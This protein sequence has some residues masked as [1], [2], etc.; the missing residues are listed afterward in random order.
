LFLLNG[1]EMQ[2]V[3][4]AIGDIPG[5]QNKASRSKKRKGRI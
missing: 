5:K 3:K 2:V 4:S 1:V